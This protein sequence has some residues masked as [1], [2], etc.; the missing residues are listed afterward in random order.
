MPKGKSE[1][2]SDVI[3]AGNRFADLF[4]DGRQGYVAFDIAV[5]AIMEERERCA[6]IADEFEIGP[7]SMWS[8]GSEQNA[9]MYG[10][11]FA[12]ETISEAI[13]RPA[14]GPIND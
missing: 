8:P 7:S 11:E 2:P 6:K 3:A 4:G 12:A 1:I 9:C 14:R 5:L 13:K 10:Q